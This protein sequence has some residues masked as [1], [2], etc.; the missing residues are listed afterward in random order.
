MKFHFTSLCHTQ[1]TCIFAYIPVRQARHIFIKTFFFFINLLS[2]IPYLPV[3]IY[4]GLFFISCLY[5]EGSERNRKQR[6]G[7]T[8]WVSDYQ[9]EFRAR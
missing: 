1:Y 5:I 2:D 3:L 6:R 9:T 7:G 4:Y 8:F